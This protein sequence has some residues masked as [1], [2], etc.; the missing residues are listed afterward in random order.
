MKLAFSTLGCPDWSWGEIFAAAR[1]IGMKGIEVRGVGREMY[2][3][4]I[5]PFRPEK[6]PET[7][8]QLRQAHMRVCMLTSSACLGIGHPEQYVEESLRY[9]DL[10]QQLGTP[11]IRVMC[12]ARA[13]P[14]TDIDTDTIARLYSRIC[15]YG[16]P[17]G[18]TPLLETNGRLADSREMRRVLDRVTSDNRG[19]LWDV[20]HP[21]RFFGEAPA[22][23]LMRLGEEIRYLHIKDS[24]MVHGQV[25]YRMMGAGD[26]PVAEAVRLMEK[27]G[28]DGFLSFEWLK[29]WCPDL[30]EPGIV[31]YQYADYMKRLLHR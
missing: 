27:R 2:A 11:Y 6:L 29:R 12:S 20:H 26:V 5:R 17:R 24:V 31:F 25:Q 16:R 28:Y 23:T 14:D 3:P 8:R 13:A 30:E 19:V 15:E 10:A 21:Y 9:V 4:A 22:E 1:D 7:V 18:V